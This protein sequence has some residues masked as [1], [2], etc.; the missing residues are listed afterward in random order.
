MPDR[1]IEVE[2]LSHSYRISDHSTVRA[3]HQVNLN[4]CHGEFVAVIGQN[5]SGKSTLAKHLNGLLIPTSG[6]VRVNGLSTGKRENIRAIRADV[7]MV[8]QNPDNQL[9]STVVEEDVAF[10]PENLGVEPDEIRKRVEWAL[11]TLDMLD[12][13][14]ESPGQLSAGQKQLVAIA[15]VLAMK[16]ACIVLDEPTALLDPM[17]RQEVLR[18]LKRLNREE[19]ITILLIT[20]FMQEAIEFDRIVVMADGEI[21]MDG[22]PRQIFRQVEQIQNLGLDLPV[23]L[24][25]ALGLTAKG[26]PVPPDTLSAEELVDHL[27]QL[28]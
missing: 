16:P 7:G 3:L 15:G 28:K 24:Q 19:G 23:P 18:S 17:A 12:Y 10:G 13:R 11:E 27:C 4:I 2:A 1:L 25:L 6:E 22:P 20:H 9:V 14:L 21:K 8:F 5:G 26:F